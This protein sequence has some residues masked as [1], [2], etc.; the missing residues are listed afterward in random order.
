MI[1]CHL[2]TSSN[3]TF[4][5]TGKKIGIWMD[6]ASAHLIE[7]SKGATQERIITSKF[8]REEKEEVLTRSEHIMHNKEQGHQHEYYKEIGEAIKGYS[9]VILFGPTDARLELFN[10]LKTNHHFENIKIEVQSADKMDAS[11]QHSFVK[12][13]FSTLIKK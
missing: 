10:T 6:H 2:W 3:F 11:E 7:Y 13:Y 4:M 8:T 5:E 9:E 1:D 12:E